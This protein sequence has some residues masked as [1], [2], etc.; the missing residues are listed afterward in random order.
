MVC[1]TY[2]IIILYDEFE[3]HGNSSR[4]YVLIGDEW[5]QNLKKIVTA[6]I[7]IIIFTYFCQIK[8]CLFNMPFYRSVWSSRR[9]LL[10]KKS[11]T[12]SREQFLLNVFIFNAVYCYQ[13]YYMGHRSAQDIRKSIPRRVTIHYRRPYAPDKQ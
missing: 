7:Y 2:L 8:L 6:Q 10:S 9:V 1:I 5:L 12:I 13:L 11:N 3:L 4:A